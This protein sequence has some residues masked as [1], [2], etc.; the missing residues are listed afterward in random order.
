MPR[1]EKTEQARLQR[2]VRVE[3]IG[4]H[5]SSIDHVKAKRVRQVTRYLSICLA[6]TNGRPAAS[7]LESGGSDELM[8]A[9]PVVCPTAA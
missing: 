1:L 4:M 5:Q 2:R 8:K 3:N 6:S 9:L 7:G